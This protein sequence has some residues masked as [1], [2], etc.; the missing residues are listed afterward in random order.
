MCPT[1]PSRGSKGGIEMSQ[2]VMPAYES[3][4]NR[5]RWTRGQ[6]EAIVEAGVLKGRY[7][8]IDGEILSKMGRKPLHI[9]VVVLVSAW[10]K[11]VF[12]D[13]YVRNQATIDVGEVDPDY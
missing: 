12:G 5:V 4:P 13:L 6:C 2:T 10:L 7:E 9:A 1:T 3:A 11:A 8:L